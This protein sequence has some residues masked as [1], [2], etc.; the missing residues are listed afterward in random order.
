MNKMSLAV[1]VLF[2]SSPFVNAATYT[3][4]GSHSSVTFKIKHVIGKVTG[5]FQQFTGNFTYDP[6]KPQAT[7]ANAVIQATSVNTSN[8]KRDNHLR[9]PDFFDVQKYPT[10]TFKG[11]HVTDVQGSKA[12]LAGQLTLHGV[13]K[14]V[15]LDL[16]I[17]GVAKDPMGKE[18]AGASATTT[19]N[20]NDFVVGPSTGPMSTMI[21]DQ[22]EISIDI[23][24]I[25]Q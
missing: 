13:T 7:T 17:A 5:N 21:G 12:K 14:P 2:L 19:I 8:E 11:D 3:I 24:G 4:D 22:V 9:T 1:A 16:D 18:R 10:I 25:K 15:V 6:A 20:R 23:E